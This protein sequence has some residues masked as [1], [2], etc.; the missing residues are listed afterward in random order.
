MQS[1][2]RYEWDVE[3]L[4]GDDI[5]DHQHSETLG[6]LPPLEQNQRLVL[7]RDFGNDLDGL[8]ERSWAYVVNDRLPDCFFD[9]AETLTN[10]HVPERFRKEL[11]EYFLRRFMADQKARQEND[12]LLR[13]VMKALTPK[14]ARALRRF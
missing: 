14:I 6:T 9:A 1:K 8:V 13:E 7:V 5:V 12:A 10:S 3:T 4:D 2:V 11:A